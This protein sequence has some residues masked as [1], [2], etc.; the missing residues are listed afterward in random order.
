VIRAL[1]VAALASSSGK[2]PVTLALAAAYRR[3]GLRVR[4]AKAGRDLIHL[5]SRLGAAEAFVAT[6]AAAAMGAHGQ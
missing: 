6:C 5:I 1:C 4:C 2:T 3:R